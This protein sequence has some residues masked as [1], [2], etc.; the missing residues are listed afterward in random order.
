[1]STSPLRTCP[2]CSASERTVLHR[3]QFIGGPLGD[4]YDVVVCSGCGCGF[5]DGIPPQPEIDRY[6][7]EQSKYTYAHLGGLESAW[8]FRR[9]EATVASLGPLLRG[10][11][12]RILDVGCATGGLLSVFKKSGFTDLTGIDP[13]PL[14]AET[15]QRL[16]GIKVT[17][18]TFAQAAASPE[19][20][21]LIL[22]LGVLEHVREAKGAVGIAKSLLRK[23]GMLYCAVPDVEGLVD[24]PNAPYQ[25][26]SFEHVNF[27]SIRSLTNLLATSEMT[28]VKTWKWTTEWRE[29]IM[30]PIASGLFAPSHEAEVEFDS[31]TVPALKVYIEESARNEVG[32]VE[33]IDSLVRQQEP[34][35]VWGAGTLARRLLA[36][37]SLSAANIVAFVDSSPQLQGKELAGKPIIAPQQLRSRP[38]P[39]LICS[40]PFRMEIL[41]AIRSLELPNR[42]ISI[43]PTI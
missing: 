18:A 25:Q 43:V 9:F 13:S 31:T 3:Q 17:A 8:D 28:P 27:F 1:M 38:E 6:Y 2:V 26:F 33:E 29:G 20:F 11:D 39:I 40:V 10:R 15:A 36:T 4:G 41:A 22:M 12:L 42:V 23:G 14:C 19:R 5:A 21:D 37:S 16:H 30:E 7:A 32:L 24:C 34:V 35:L